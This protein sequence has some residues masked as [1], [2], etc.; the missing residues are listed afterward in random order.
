MANNNGVITFEQLKKT[1]EYIKVELNKKA[2]TVHDTHVVFPN[3]N[4]Y[5]A[6]SFGAEGAVGMSPKC[7]RSDHT[8]TLPVLPTSL[9]NPN[10]LTIQ[11]DGVEAL[12]YDGSSAKT[13]NISCAS[14][15]ASPN[16]HTHDFLNI[17][18][19]DTISSTS[20]DTVSNWA[21]QKNSV[22]WY[23]TTGLLTDQPQQYG[24]ISNY[25]NAGDVHQLWFSQPGG[26]I[27]HRGGNG[28]GWS[29]SWRRI[30]DDTNYTNIVASDSEVSAMLLQA[31]GNVSVGEGSITTNATNQEIIDMINNIFK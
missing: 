31:F 6:L 22:H 21:S 15:S 17:K 30:I 20:N 5:T 11:F 29:T 27:C 7:A 14:I 10:K 9:K 8:H 24:F 18:G 25:A 28:A 3:V 23:K 13:L 4:E 16:T 19:T 1:A 12:Q 2:N 26:D